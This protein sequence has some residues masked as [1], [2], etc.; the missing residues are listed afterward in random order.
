M[1]RGSRWKYKIDS[2]IRVWRLRGE[3]YIPDWVLP[4]A[5]FGGRSVMSVGHGILQLQVGA[6][7]GP[8]D[9]KCTTIPWRSL[10]QS[11]DPQFENHALANRLIFMQDGATPHRARISR[12]FLQDAAIDVLPW[13][14]MSPDLNPI[15]QIWDYMYIRCQLNVMDPKSATCRT[16]AGQFRACGEICH[17]VQRCR[18]VYMQWSWPTGEIQLTERRA[19]RHP[20]RHTPIPKNESFSRIVFKTSKALTQ[21]T[22]IRPK[23]RRVGDSSLRRPQARGTTGGRNYQLRPLSKWRRFACAVSGGQFRGFQAT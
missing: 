16:F 13:P 20:S 5:M 11:F 7:G 6:D 15:V 21:K 19:M 1:R 10:D 14:S 8:G 2:R 18:G 17:L 3:R 22:F 12:T 23:I 9:T 4:R